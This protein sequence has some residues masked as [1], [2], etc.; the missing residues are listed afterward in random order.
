[1]LRAMGG[2]MRAAARGLGIGWLLLAT[3][4][5]AEPEASGEDAEAAAQE[6]LEE[7]GE[8][9]DAAPEPGPDPG[10]SCHAGANP[11]LNE[12]CAVGTECDE[13]VRVADF[14]ELYNP[15]ATPI[16]LGCFLLIGEEAIPFLPDGWLAPHARAAWGEGELGFRIRK[17]DD[18]IRL[19]RLL[20]RDGQ[21]PE[22]RE[23]EVVPV[24]ASRAL[25]YRSPDGGAWVH[26]GIDDAE[27]GWPGS[28]GEPNPAPGERDPE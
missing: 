21:E 1:M 2:R 22:L 20:P 4:A 12:V 10:G 11:L 8:P 28:F 25:S 5:G 26:L 15:S 27:Y 16:D 6:Q 7:D 18:R 19:Y 9:L 17:A 14:V 13:D 24:D 3:A 23:L